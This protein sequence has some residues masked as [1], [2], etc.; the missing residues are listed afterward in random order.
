MESSRKIHKCSEFIKSNLE[1]KVRHYN[2]RQ[3]YEADNNMIEYWE[4]ETKILRKDL[5]E[6]P[7][8]GNK[9]ADDKEN[10][11]VGAHVVDENQNRYITPTCNSCNSTYKESRAKE[12]W[13][14]VRKKHL[15]QL[16]R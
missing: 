4:E 7:C 15:C 3:G 16:P 2:H 9:V 8:C 10:Y 11:W 5:T 12:K 14:N 13:F 1:V 6:C